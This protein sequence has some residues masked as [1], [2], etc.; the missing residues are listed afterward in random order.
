MNSDRVILG[1][2]TREFI[3]SKN[4]LSKFS[5]YFEIMF[6]KDFVE[7][8]MSRIKINVSNKGFQLFCC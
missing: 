4:V 6:T 8:E 5:E 3:C 2:G 7:K 1:V